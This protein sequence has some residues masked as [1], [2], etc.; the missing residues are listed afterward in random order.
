MKF[1]CQIFYTYLYNRK[2]CLHFFPTCIVH[3]FSCSFLVFLLPF[4]SYNLICVYFPIEIISNI[5]EPKLKLQ[6][7]TMKMCPPIRPNLILYHM[8]FNLL[9]LRQLIKAPFAKTYKII[10]TASHAASHDLEMLGGE[11]RTKTLL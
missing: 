2:S 3:A 11:V 9:R 6:T 10:K 5:I 1:L 4:V 7:I 8:I